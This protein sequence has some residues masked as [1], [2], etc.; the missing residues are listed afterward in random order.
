MQDTAIFTMADQWR[1]VQWLWT[2]PN[3]VFKATLF[4]AAEYLLN[5]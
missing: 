4:F 3:P 2:T 5:G 1:H